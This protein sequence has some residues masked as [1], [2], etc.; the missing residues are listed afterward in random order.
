MRDDVV[1]RST[2]LRKTPTTPSKTPT[3]PTP[4][5]TTTTKTP[6]KQENE[7]ISAWKNKVIDTI[8]A[9]FDKVVFLRKRNGLI[10]FESGPFVYKVIE[11]TNNYNSEIEAY[12]TFH[13]LGIASSFKEIEIGD[14]KA[15]KLPLLQPLQDEDKEALT[16]VLNIMWGAGWKHGDICYPIER[17]ESSFLIRDKNFMKDDKGHIMLIDFEESSNKDEGNV[18]IEKE[19]WEQARFIKPSDNHI[20]LQTDSTIDTTPGGWSGNSASQK[21]EQTCSIL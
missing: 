18:R 1:Y 17:G 15:I 20:S 3:T 21:K 19:E 4:T 13:D 8:N 14:H 12:K 5:T 6:I 2:T 7:E 11:S 10:I 16:K 9:N